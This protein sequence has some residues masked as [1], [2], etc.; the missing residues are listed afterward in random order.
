M[1][2]VRTTRTFRKSLKKLA[3]SGTFNLSKLEKLIDLLISDKQL[4]KTYSD[5]KLS[6][7]LFHYRECHVTPDILLVYNKNEQKLVLHI[8]NI[9]SHSELF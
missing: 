2:T 5:H 1:Y 6:G 4:P 7:K 9:G 3:K 8:V